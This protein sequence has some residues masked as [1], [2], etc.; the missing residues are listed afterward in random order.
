MADEDKEKLDSTSEP[1]EEETLELPA[2]EGDT[3]TDEGDKPKEEDTVEA[4]KAK[5]ASL[6]ARAKKAEGFIQQPDGS[7]V[8]PPKQEKKEPDGNIHGQVSATDPAEITFTSRMAARGLSDDEIDERIQRARTIA[9]GSG[10]SLSEAFK[11]P[12]F[13]AFQSLRD[14]ELKKERAKLGGTKG[15]SQERKPSFDTGL[16]PEGTKAHKEQWKEALA[17]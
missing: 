15:S 14:E 8:K 3:S 16:T 4:L 7:W 17:K 10:V 2:N 12:M 1:S 13:V 6:F 11:D 5:N 9:K